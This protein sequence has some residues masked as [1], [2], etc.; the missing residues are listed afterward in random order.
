[1]AAEEKALA[2]REE[3]AV[4]TAALGQLTREQ[5][6]LIKST[7][8]KGATD[9]ELGMFIEEC[10]TLG[11]NPFAKEIFF[12]K[13]QTKAGDVVAMPIGIDGR[14]KFADRNPDYRGQVGPFWCG[15]DGE[16]KDVWLSDGPPAAAKVGIFL[17]GQHEPT[18][19]IATWRE[20]NR[21]GQAGDQFW[22]RS[23]AHMLAIRAES[24]ALR[25]VAIQARE[26]GPAIDARYL[27][28]KAQQISRD[29]AYPVH[30]RPQSTRELREEL[31]GGAVDPETGEIVDPSAEADERAPD[32]F[33]EGEYVEEEPSDAAGRI[34]SQVMDLIA[35]REGQAAKAGGVW[36]DQP[37]TDAQRRALA[38]LL[39]EALEA[40]TKG[41]RYAVYEY[42][43]G[44]ADSGEMN[45]AECG[46]LLAWLAEKG[47]NDR[48]ALRDGAAEEAK[49]V[50]RAAMRKQGQQE[51]F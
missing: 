33:E 26:S 40:K 44:N 42:L 28:L 8:A 36:A 31:F 1:M 29:Q 25:K 15:P 19:G 51:L 37:A 50:Y 22:R 35:E 46:A 48:L 2:R 47:D 43:T 11:L 30:R 7:I 41:E 45:M 4:Q 14:R 34:K 5:V 18:W 6:E 23:P 24:H 38:M 9:D 10:N 32:A 27:A 16:W 12:I 20:F 13:Y 21:V 3:S 49:I 39:D 17:E